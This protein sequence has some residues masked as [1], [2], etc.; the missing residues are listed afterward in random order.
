MRNPL[1]SGPR[2]YLRLMEPADARVL[3]RSDLVTTET[4]YMERGRVPTSAMAFAHMLAELDKQDTR[5]TY[6][7]AI[8]LNDSDEMIGGTSI[9]DIDWVNRNAETGIGIFEEQFRNSGYGPEA[10]HLSLKYA[11]E[12]LGMHAM[13]SDVY[14]ANT[15]SVAAL[16]K[17]GYQPAG[18]VESEI[19]RFGI[20]RDILVFDL[21][22]SEWEAAYAAWQ[23]RSG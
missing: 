13:R 4:W 10:K 11:F 21:L 12:T 3:S 15:R 20:Y 8:C 18:K 16:L 23:H 14:E 19:C 2:I 17:Q 1:V 6:Y 9:R 5:S 22:R 7:F